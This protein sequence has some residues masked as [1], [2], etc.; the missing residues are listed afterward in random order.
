[1]SKEFETINF[2]WHSPPAPHWSV[3]FTHLLFLSFITATDLDFSF[4]SQIENNL[5]LLLYDMIDYLYLVILGL[6]VALSTV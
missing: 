6:M 2:L 1:M 5:I 4:K 3:N